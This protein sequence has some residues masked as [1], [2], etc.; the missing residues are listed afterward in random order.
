MKS[1]IIPFEAYKIIDNQLQN[2]DSVNIFI[3]LWKVKRKSCKTLTKYWFGLYIDYFYY[4]SYI[5]GKNVDLFSLLGDLIKRDNFASN[6][7]ISIKALNIFFLDLQKVNEK[8]QNPIFDDIDFIKELSYEEVISICY[9]EN[10]CEKN[11]LWTLMT[12]K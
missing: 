12:S 9:N 11:I 4:S 3:P 8:I 1:E 10:D 7:D 2:N 5:S 6:N